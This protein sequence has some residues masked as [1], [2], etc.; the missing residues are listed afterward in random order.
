MLQSMHIKGVDMDYRRDSNNSRNN[1]MYYNQFSNDSKK[2]PKKKKTSFASQ[3][4]KPSEMVFVIEGLEAYFYT[5]YFVGVPYVTGVLFLFFA[6][7]G[8]EFENLISLDLTAFFIVWA[9]GYEI[10]ATISL[11]WIFTLFL[12]YDDGME[13]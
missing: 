12:K 2:T 13:Y 5:F 3:E 4:V 11:I 1:R 10:V 9:I 8:G 6:I 7:A